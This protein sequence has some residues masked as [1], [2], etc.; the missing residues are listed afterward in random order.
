MSL[1]LPKERK[2]FWRSAAVA[3]PSRSNVRFYTRES[4]WKLCSSLFHLGQ[5]DYCCGWALPQPRSGL[6]LALCLCVQTLNAADSI[7]AGDILIADFEGDDYGAW[8]VEGT[9]FGNGPAHGT[10]PGQ[11]V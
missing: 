10:L 2:L 1:L 4:L 8:K 6:I 11:M 7:A 3:E 9:A 5:F